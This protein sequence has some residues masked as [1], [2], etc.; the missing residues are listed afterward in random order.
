MP[1]SAGRIERR[2]EELGA[3]FT[4]S[5]KERVK[6]AAERAGKT[7]S[8]FVRE[9]VL[10]LADRVLKDDALAGF[11]TFIGMVDV[12]DVHAREHSE[13]FADLILE[14]HAPSKRRTRR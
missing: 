2:D 9:A 13:A 12:P 8:D 3:R 5:Q 11:D 7:P 1:R 6:A 14:K 4:R 10:S